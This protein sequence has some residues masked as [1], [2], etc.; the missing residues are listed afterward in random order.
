MMLSASGLAI[1]ALWALRWDGLG[2]RK[3]SSKATDKLPD[4]CSVVVCCHN[5]EARIAD[6]HHALLPA[7]VH[8]ESCGMHVQ[9]VAVNHGSTDGTAQ[10]LEALSDR[11]GW[12]VV[13]QARTRPSKKEALEAG[14]L[15]ATGESVVVTDLD[16]T[17][18]SP[19][20]LEL[21]LRGAAAQWDV[22][23]G[24]SLPVRGAGRLHALQQLEAER[25]AQKAVG[26]VVRAR[27][28]LGFGR[29]MAFTREMWVRVG[30]MASTSTSEAETTTSGCKK[31]SRWVPGS[32]R[33]PH[34]RHRPPQSGRPL[35]RRGEGKKQGMFPPALCTPQPRWHD[36]PCPALGQ[37]FLPPGLSTILRGHRFFARG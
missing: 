9:V 15:A 21:M 5:E 17:P 6:F 11:S 1:H 2:P 22:C 32:R 29:N 34:P 20:W 7:L 3:T 26:A 18:L 25:T 13:H 10:A 12:I 14:M 27:P 19:E 37:G 35:G 31:L 33:T 4:S 28:Y 8:A 23:V 16:C 24:L 30:G 36:W